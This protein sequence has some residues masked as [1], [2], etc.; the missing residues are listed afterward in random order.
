MLLT[1]PGNG[2]DQVR[3]RIVPLQSQARSTSIRNRTKRLHY[4]TSPWYARGTSK[5]YALLGLDAIGLV[6]RLVHAMFQCPYVINFQA[7]STLL[8][9]TNTDFIPDFL[10][11]EKTLA[12]L[13][14]D[15]M[16]KHRQ[17]FYSLAW[18]FPAAWLCGCGDKGSVASS[19][20]LPRALLILV[21]IS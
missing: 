5:K 10:M 12:K 11:I 1:I 15:T 19:I 18:A 6:E 4:I 16:S 14:G 13:C 7:L 21:N 2:I 8:T 3:D 20:L 9:P 17:C